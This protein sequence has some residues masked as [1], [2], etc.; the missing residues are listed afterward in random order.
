[1]SDPF[2]IDLTLLSDQVTRAL[3]QLGGLDAARAGNGAPLWSVLTKDLGLAGVAL[4]EQVG[5]LGSDLS[6]LVAISRCLG[7]VLAPTGFVTHT[8]AA[9]ILA[10]APQPPSL[11]ADIARGAARVTLV[12]AHPWGVATSEPR[13]APDGPIA[14]LAA[15]THH[16]RLV[17]T[18]TGPALCLTKA[19]AVQTID[20]LDITR[21]MAR[22]R[23]GDSFP[24]PIWQALVGPWIAPAIARAR[25]AAAAETAGAAR[26]VFDLTR[27]YLAER[28]QFGRQI[29]S[30]QA[31]KH[32]VADL[33]VALN[34]VDA[35]IDAAARTPPGPVFDAEALGAQCRAVAVLE[36]AA[37]EAIQLHGGIGVTAEAAPHLFFKRA[38]ALRAELGAD[39]TRFAGIGAQ[40]RQGDLASAPSSGEDA[41]RQQVAAWMDSA[42]SGD[43]AVLRDRGHAGDGDALPQLRRTWEAK[44]ASGG[45]L[46][47]GVPQA[48]GGRGF[49]IPQQVAFYEEYARAGGPGRMGHIGEGL[50]APTLLQFGT[51]DQI[52]RH[53]PGVLRGEVFWAQGYSEPGAGSDLAAIRTRAERQPDGSWRVTGQKIWTSLAH[54]SDWIFVLARADAGSQGRDGLVFLLM[55]LDQPG[56]SIRPIAQMNGGAEFN[57]VWFDGA[58]AQADDLL[59]KVGQGW[60]IAMALLG[61][62]RGLSTL[63]QQM[64]FARELAQIAALAG[65]E[66]DARLG[67]AWVGLRAMRHGAQAMLSALEAGQAG[68]EALGYKLEWSHW[69]RDLGELALAVLG[70]DAASWPNDD[71]AAQR[72]MRMALFTRA[73]TIYGGTSEIQLN[74][75]AERGLNMPRERRGG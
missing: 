19:S 26:A 73:D 31:I 44:L 7:A 52:A 2:D 63:G 41:L 36:R 27:A 16:L 40:L 69:H 13:S 29:D 66:H 42:L 71:S 48:S 20:P 61:Y 1:M 18:P 56:I 17:K 21:P 23:P 47:L 70:A 5:G 14:H 12:V 72:L 50:L 54:V 60:A 68:P 37:A 59:G 57:E 74:I 45:W 8:L 32:R 10:A 35:L 43:F 49:S 11:L 6:P 25:L 46:G 33:F 30:Y 51:D 3:S 75:I 28:Q 39:E 53:L 67:R 65:P 15:A 55:P 4:P 38:I 64:G 34:S 24:N 62:E 58:V 9:Q 22:L